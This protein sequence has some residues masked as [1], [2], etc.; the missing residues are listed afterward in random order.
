MR[1]IF[2]FAI[3]VIALLLSLH[4]ASALVETKLH[5]TIN[6]PASAIDVASSSDG[7]WTFVLTA[8]GKLHIYSADGQ[9]NDIVQ[10][11]PAADRILVNGQ[12]GELLL[13]S[14]STKK[15]VQLMTL[16]FAAEID[17]TGS[18]Y[19][20]NLAAPVTVV[21][22][23]DFQCPFCAKLG[24]VIEQ[25]LD[26]YPEDVKVVF[27]HFPLASHRFASLAALASV[28]AQKQGKFWQFHDALFAA[29]K[30]LSQS[31]ILSLAGDLGLD[32]KQFTADIGSQDAKDRLTKDVNDGKAAGLHGT[33]T[34]FVNG[35]QPDK[36]TFEDVKAMIEAELKILKQ[37]K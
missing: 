33:P 14:S 10:V 15:T 31:K 26:A 2:S 30:D 7:T 11:D 35:R 4:P 29:Q 3:S 21:I 18:P 20:G 13:V 22:F 12:Q 1:T 16:T 17:V 36:N 19:L 23:S 37:K 28:A 25:T 5:T 24:P 27:K 8:G 6:M 32:I 9:L 34:L